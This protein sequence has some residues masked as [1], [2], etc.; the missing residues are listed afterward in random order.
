MNT[1]ITEE[2]KK[3]TKPIHDKLDESEFFAVLKEGKLPIESYINY[4]QVMA[5]IN[6]AFEKEVCDSNHLELQ[7]V[8]K[9]SMSKLPP[10]LVDLESL[11]ATEFEDIPMAI[12][13]MLDTIKFIRLC[14][15]ENPL[16]LLGVMYV[17][18]G[19]TLGGAIL[20]E[21]VLKNFK[22]QNNSGVLF[23]DHYKK[24]KMQN[25]EEFKTRVNALNLNQIERSAILHTAID[26]FQK[27]QIIFQHLY[28]ISKTIPFYNVTTLNPEAG[29]HRIPEDR[30]EIQ[31]ALKAGNKTWEDFPYF[32]WRYGLRGKQFTRSDSAWLVTLCALDEKFVLQQIEWL[33]KILSTR[34]MPHLL[35]CIHLENL[36]NE[37]SLVHPDKVSHYHK[38]LFASEKLNNAMEMML[39][40]SVREEIISEFEKNIG[41]EWNHRLKNMGQILVASV[42][43]ERMGVDNALSSVESWAT[44]EN[45]FPKIW[46]DSVRTLIA[47]TQ[48]AC[49]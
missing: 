29:R 13:A 28:P 15:A 30:L 36:V 46:I 16:Y 25:W 24:Q 38:L 43:D 37:L 14:S 2:L 35:L 26:F 47:N 5:G 11:H 31:A 41:Q 39:K 3:A 19:S 48:K 23:L 10:L 22:F 21:L 8:W 12:D 44:D 34:G 17:L 49:A 42:A 9:D 45:R 4:L 18:E 6:A 1:K 27:I 40:K 33:G 32:A 20:K 7:S